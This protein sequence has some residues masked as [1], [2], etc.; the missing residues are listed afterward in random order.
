MAPDNGLSRREREVMDIVH[1]LE[2]ATAAQIRTA[3]A[4]PPTDA[5]VR[6][7]L[8]ILVRKDHL[9]F[10]QNGPRYLYRPTIPSKAARRSAVERVAR[11]FFDGS[12]EG[13]MAALLEVRGPLTSEEKKRLRK[14][15]DNAREEGR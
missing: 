14:L 3:M 2:R 8:R 7:I 9:E 12:V 13:V 15:I 1:R 5:A 10:E 4:Q 11:T 6:S